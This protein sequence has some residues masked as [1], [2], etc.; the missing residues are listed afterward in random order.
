MIHADHFYYALLHC[1]YIQDQIFLNN[2]YDEPTTIPLY[3]VD[4]EPNEKT[5]KTFSL[6][7]Q[8]EP[9]LSTGFFSLCFLLVFN[10]N[11]TTLI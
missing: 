4:S 5:T 1:V 9:E 11:L 2:I 6:C 10:S 7:S 8:T 3:F